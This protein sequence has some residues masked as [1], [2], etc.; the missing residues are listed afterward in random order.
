MQLIL[1]HDLIKSEAVWVW[2]SVLALVTGLMSLRAN[3]I[4]VLFSGF[5]SLMCSILNH[6]DYGK[7]VFKWT[8]KLMFVDGE[9]LSDPVL[10]ALF[11]VSLWFYYHFAEF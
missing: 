7:I 10:S 2:G 8:Q 9:K 6:R 5:S 4:K 1:F 3:G 11:K